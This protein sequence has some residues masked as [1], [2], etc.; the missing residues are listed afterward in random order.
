MPYV[1]DGDFIDKGKQKLQ[2]IL[3]K[4]KL[5]FENWNLKVN[6]TKTEFTDISISEKKE[7]RGSESWRDQNTLGSKACSTKDMEHRILL[8]NVAFRNMHKIWLKGTN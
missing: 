3:P 1:D 2:E 7:Q 8:S 6:P 5:V 4:L